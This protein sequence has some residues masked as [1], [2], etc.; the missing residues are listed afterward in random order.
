MVNDDTRPLCRY[1][2]RKGCRKGDKC[3]FYHP[4]SI[5][6]TIRKEYDRERGRCY[7]GCQLKS[8]INNRYIRNDE[9]DP[10]FFVVCSKTKK[11][12]KKCG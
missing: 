10:L 6:P 8:I 2:Y 11:S 4:P 3:R 9:N 12:M 7:C 1:F 5:T